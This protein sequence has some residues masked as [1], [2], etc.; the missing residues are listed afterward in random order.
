M[1][2]VAKVE[3]AAGTVELKARGEG[4]W[5]PLGD[6]VNVKTGD[7]LRTGDD[8][9]V[10]LSW[11]DGTR[12]K[13]D[14]NSSMVIQKSSFNG[15]DR[16]QES[17]FRLDFGRV[18]VRVMQLLTRGSK[19]EIETPAATAGIRG[20]IF[21]VSAAAD[22]ATEVSVYKGEVAV[23]TAH[24]STIVPQGQQV[25][26]RPDG[27]ASEVASL[28]AAALKRW[29]AQHDMV[30]PRLAVNAPAKAP[31]QPGL[32][33]ITGQTDPGAEVTVNGAAAPVNALGRFHA[34]VAAGDVE[35]QGSVEVV[36]T[37]RTGSKRAVSVKL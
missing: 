17:L 24:A 34:T 5:R 25:S 1:Q 37:D 32:L 8:S 30:M 11:V 27:S 22:G 9:S 33:E 4:D 10:V 29:Q 7:A 16:K 31:D 2:R 36:A 13:L 12:M 14:P 21:A 19:F 18:W 20:T 35:K 6:T 15:L 3:Q 23:T 28:D 26:V